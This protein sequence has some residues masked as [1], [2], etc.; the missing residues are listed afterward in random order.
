MSTDATRQMGCRTC[1]SPLNRYLDLATGTVRYTHPANPTGQPADHEPDPAPADQVD[2]HHVCDFC[3]DEHIVYTFRT[4]RLDMLVLAPDEQLIQHYGS[5]WSACLECA[6]LVQARDVR[7]L[8]SRI[9]RS[10]LPFDRQTLDGIRAMQQAVVDSLLPGRAVAEIGRWQPTPLHASVLPKV[11]DRLARLIRGDDDLPCGLGLPAM[12]AQV[13]AGLDAAR[14]YWIDPEFT[15]LTTHAAAAL[16]ATTVTTADAPAPHGLLAW[17]QPVGQHGDITAAAWTGGPHGIRIVCYRSIGAGL[18]PGPLQR[19][20]EQVGWLV[21][22]YT[23]L[24]R[25]DHAVDA[26]SPAGIV[27]ATW[28]LISQTLAEVTPIEPDKAIRKA[29]QRTGRPAPEVRLVRLRGTTTTA[30]P[31]AARQP[32]AQPGRDHEYRW[33]VRGHWRNQPYGPGRCRRRLIYLDPHVRGPEDKPIKASTVVRI[34]GTAR[35]RSRD[36]KP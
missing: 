7:G 36:D 35:P 30:E 19:L 25:P 4:G 22:R 2:V 34:L 26:T 16:P 1:G 17:A 9:M 3:S 6:E 33:W 5:D 29:Y 13:A 15:D 21:P 14:L 27:V 32:N 10:G 28:L 11:R 24:L 20:R 18:Q 8:A 31:A 23:T 12:R